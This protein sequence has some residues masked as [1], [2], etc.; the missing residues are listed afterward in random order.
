[1]SKML[2]Y[3]KACDCYVTP[4]QTRWAEQWCTS[5]WQHSTH[6]HRNLTGKVLPVPNTHNN[7]LLLCPNWRVTAWAL[8]KWKKQK[9]VTDW[10]KRER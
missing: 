2:Q 6:L 9:R 5:S 7:I 8:N 4:G 1:M 3:G 10:D